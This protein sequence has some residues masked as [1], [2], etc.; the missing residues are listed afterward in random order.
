ME[1]VGGLFC[2]S[3]SPSHDSTSRAPTDGANTVYS[4]TLQS[5]ASFQQ[6][7]LPP[8]LASPTSAPLVPM[9][10]TIST[11]ILHQIQQHLDLL[12]PP[13]LDFLASSEPLAPVE[14]TIPT[15]DTTTEEV[16]ILPPQEATTDAIAS[17][18]P[19]D[20]PQTVDTITATPEDA[21]SPPKAPTT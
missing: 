21:S 8:A 9:P 11:A 4:S 2:T 1:S 16:Q 15:E 3:K 7:L 12:P 5:R 6:R 14:D 19:Q 10:E 20:E 13:Q 18:D 17:V